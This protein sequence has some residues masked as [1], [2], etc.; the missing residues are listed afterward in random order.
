MRGFFLYGGIALLADFGRTVKQ[1]G[2]K[3]VEYRV[4]A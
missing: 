3:S 4:L 2:G 1:M